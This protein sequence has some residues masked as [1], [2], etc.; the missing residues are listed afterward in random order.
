[1]DAVTCRFTISYFCQNANLHCNNRQCADD[2]LMIIYRIWICVAKTDEHLTYIGSLCDLKARISNVV[3]TTLHPFCFKT[4][5]QGLSYWYLVFHISIV[6]AQFNGISNLFESR[7]SVYIYDIILLLFIKRK[8]KKES[9][10][11]SVSACNS[12]CVAW[13]LYDK[14][15]FFRCVH[16]DFPKDYEPT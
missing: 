1:M 12:E 2:N 6:C 4:M 5:S 9:K 8:K 11:K 16:F 7:H 3:Y 13:L 14:T 10:F 15:I